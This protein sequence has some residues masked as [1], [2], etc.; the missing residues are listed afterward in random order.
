M[1][2]KG[3]LSAVAPWRRRSKLM[4]HSSLHQQQVPTLG[5]TTFCFKCNQF[6]ACQWNFIEFA[7][8]TLLCNLAGG[9]A[10]LGRT[11]FEGQRQ[12]PLFGRAM[13]KMPDRKKLPVTS[14]E[15]QSSFGDCC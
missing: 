12:P 9:D 10:A 15:S 7:S 4:S 5:M 11:N 6:Y 3:R 1:N 8:I 14:R 2:M 13:C